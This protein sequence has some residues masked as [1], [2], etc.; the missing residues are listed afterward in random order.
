M[1]AEWSEL[2]GILMRSGAATTVGRVR[3]HNEDSLLNV[4]GAY[5]VADGMG[6]HQAGD[7]ASAL[8]IDAVAAMVGDGVPRI[9]AITSMIHDA[10]ASVRHY[11]ETTG[12]LG[13]GTTLVGAFVVQNADEYSVVIANVGDSRC[14]SL[15][16][17]V[18][19]QVTTD[20]SH[21]QELVSAGSLTAEEARHHKDRNIV[22][23]A[24]GVD[25][26]V[27]ADYSISDPTTRERLM[28]CS[29]GVSG[30]LDEAALCR[31]LTEHVDPQDA[32]DAV[33]E[34]VMEGRA[35][36]NAT[37]IVVDFEGV[38]ALPPEP[39]SYAEDITQPTRR[40]GLPAGAPL[41]P[42]VLADPPPPADA[43]D[44]RSDPFTSPPVIDQVPGL[45][46]GDASAPAADVEL[47]REVM[48][49]G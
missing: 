3:Q 12:Q 4:A 1:E 26:V 14:Y 9:T 25:P 48:N 45:M 6:G 41:A 2:G 16:D 20:H 32:A 39:P 13:M 31:L 40:D 29:D 27:S 7:I 47:I 15:R 46:P 18:L 5:V 33:I 36:D 23:R 19:R 8:T 49:G 44:V 22:T 10:N 43:G 35:A 24:V 34:A 37:L 11:A 38:V 30:E 28:L 21:V 42:P 17:G